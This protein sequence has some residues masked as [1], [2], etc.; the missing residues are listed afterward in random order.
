MRQ[1]RL[2]AGAL[3]TE[4]TNGLDHLPLVPYVAENMSSP[5]L[6]NHLLLVQWEAS[7]PTPLSTGRGHD[8]YSKKCADP[9]NQP[10]GLGFLV[11]LFRASLH[12]NYPEE[13]TDG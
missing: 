3:D 11:A 8:Y 7:A 6:R 13:T 1:R 2:P 4:K 9:W 10:V 12:G 5:R